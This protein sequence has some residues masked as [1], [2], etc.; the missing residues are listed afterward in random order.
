[1]TDA[2]AILQLDDSRFK[3]TIAADIAAMS[4]LFADELVY[5]HSNGLV[6]SKE[7]YLEAV[8]AKKFDYQDVR[9]FDQQVA[10]H[11][12]TALVTGRAEID[13]N[14]RHLNCRFLT[15]WVNQAGTWRFAAWQSTPL[16]A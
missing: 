2:N 16:P 12:D 13:V 1:M 6:D 5:T 10:L 8:A 14:G 15:V 3:A 11:G 4:E 7:S 9:R